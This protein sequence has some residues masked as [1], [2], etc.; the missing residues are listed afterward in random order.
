MLDPTFL[1]AYLIVLVSLAGLG[2]VILMLIHILWVGYSGLMREPRR[3]E[4]VNRY[5]EQKARRRTA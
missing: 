3:G 2:M 5:Q 1:G 4:Y